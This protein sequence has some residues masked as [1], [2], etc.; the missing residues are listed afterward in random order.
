VVGSLL[1]GDEIVDW[2]GV[3]I[4]VNPG[5]LLGYYLYFFGEYETPVI[6]KTIDLCAGARC[7]VDVGANAGFFSLAVAQA[8]PQVSV[9][10]FEPDTEI[11]ATFAANL[12]LNGNLSGRVR[13]IQNAVGEVDGAAVF[14]PSP[15]RE[16]PG[17][18]RLACHEDPSRGYA[19]RVRRLD[20]FFQTPPEIVK[21]DVE[22]GELQVLRGMAG[23]FAAGWP[24]AVV[25][26]THGGRFGAGQDDFNAQVVALLEQGGYAVRC[27]REGTWVP[28]TRPS[29]AGGRSHLLAVR[30]DVC[31]GQ[32]RGGVET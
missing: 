5:H 3:R 24:R 10:A 19:V 1:W 17:L 13:L 25:V 27:R 8:C 16:N 30:R 23:L 12:R 15:R 31:A 7:F 32:G 2:R 22:G 20:S 6:D 11:A 18:G 21:I 14:L 4:R 26:E 29:E 28:L 9:V